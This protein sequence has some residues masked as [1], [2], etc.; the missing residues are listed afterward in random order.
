MATPVCEK[1]LDI[2]LELIRQ[3]DLEDELFEAEINNTVGESEVPT[4]VL[5][6]CGCGKTGIMAINTMLEICLLSQHQR[7]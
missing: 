2:I 6:C 3:D 4:S 7:T 1:D 5:N